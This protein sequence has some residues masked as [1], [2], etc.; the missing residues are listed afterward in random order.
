MSKKYAR[1]S[2]YGDILLPMS[3]LEKVIEEGYI[4]ATDYSN[5]DYHITKV[6]EIKSVLFHDED[7]IRCILA[8]QAL[9]EDE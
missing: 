8:Q 1:I 2:D 3:L 6:R 5:G 7:E 9:S 4:V